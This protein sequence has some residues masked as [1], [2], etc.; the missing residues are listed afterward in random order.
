MSDD[1]FETALQKTMEQTFDV[2]ELLAAGQHLSD[3]G[4]HGKTRLLYKIWIERNKEHP[5]LHAVLFNYGVFLTNSSELDAARETYTQAIKL[6]PDFMPAHINLGTVFERMGA[7]DKAVI[8]WSEAANTLPAVTGDAVSYKATA[9]KQMGRVLETA[10][11]SEA[12][13]I[14]LTQCLDVNPHQRDV[15]QHLIALRQAQCKWPVVAPW[16]NIS[17]KQLIGSISPLSLLAYADD[18][19][20]QLANAYHYN[21]SDVDDPSL[22]FTASPWPAPEKPLNRRLRVGYI[23]SDLREHA[24]GFL[25]SEVFELHDRN[26]V[27]VFAYYCGIRSD[28]A[29][30]ARIKGAVEHWIDITAMSDQEAARQISDDGVDILVDLNGYTKDARL[31]VFAMRPAPII[32]NWLG[33][34]GT[35]GSAYHNYIIADD[36]IIPKEYEL[37]YSEKVMRLPCYQPSDRKRVVAANAPT[38][39]SEGLPEDATVFCCF[40]GA[41]KF[42]RFTFERW[43]TILRET[44][45]SVLWL[46]EGAQGSTERLREQASQLGAAPERLIFAG[47]LA[48]PYHLA[49]YPLADLFLDTSPYGAHTTG[50]DALWMGAPVL[51]ASGRSFTSRVCGSLV[52]AAGLGDLVCKSQDEYVARAIELGSNRALLQS[53]REKLEANRHSCVLFD[54][55]NLVSSLETLYQRMWDDHARGITPTPNLA[56]L[57]VYHDIGC[58]L[59]HERDDFSIL[60]DYHSIYRT[61]LAFRHGFNPLGHDPRLWTEERAASSSPAIHMQLTRTEKPH[62]RV[63]YSVYANQEASL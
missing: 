63:N 57:G 4:E 20:L 18:P 17:K 27:E 3:T 51:T 42:T 60:S 2:G 13:E 54:T 41:Q 32:V 46:L 14:T 31:K 56:N 62:G 30:H 49:R 33:Y 48:N 16:G 55:N 8:Q 38:R 11:I 23:S 58:S 7:L 9:L 12:A 45:D 35:M 37:Y 44:P 21:K 50:S 43:M 6:R 40:N 24:V 29:T 28:D 5:L 15:T 52:K 22:F 53:Y 47:K 59:E 61:R 39:Q 1:F 34:P 19:L 10:H 25:M 36:H 26:K